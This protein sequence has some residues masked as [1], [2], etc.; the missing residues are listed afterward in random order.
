[1]VVR[2]PRHITIIRTL[3]ILKQASGAVVSRN[4]V[5]VHYVEIYVNVLSPKCLSTDNVVTVK[6]VFSLTF[7][8]RIKYRLHMLA[9]LGAHHILHVFR[10]RVKL[11][12]FSKSQ[13]KI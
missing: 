2:I 5:R 13:K 12:W 1:M 11:R 8:R 7:K 10:I 6:F 4:Q 9:L 3:P